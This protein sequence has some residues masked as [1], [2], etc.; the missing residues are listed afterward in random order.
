MTESL[1]SSFHLHFLTI[2]IFSPILLASFLSTSCCTFLSLVLHHLFFSSLNFFY[3]AT[4]STQDWLANSTSTT[5]LMG[6]ISIFP[7]S[8]YSHFQPVYEHGLHISYLTIHNLKYSSLRPVCYTPHQETSSLNTFISSVFQKQKLHG[9]LALFSLSNLQSHFSVYFHKFNKSIL[10][11][12][13]I[14]WCFVS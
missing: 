13:G 1:I 3:D 12:S 2:S 14:L 5:T 8:N 10:Y 9:S 4:K 7:A 6:H 11:K